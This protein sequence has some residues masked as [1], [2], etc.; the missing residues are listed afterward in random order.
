[1]TNEE[2]DEETSALKS[3]VFWKPIIYGWPQVS[4]NE[5]V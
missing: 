5:M 2:T 4:S 3:M 1:M